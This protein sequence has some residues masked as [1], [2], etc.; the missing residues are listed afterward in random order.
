MVSTMD[1]HGRILGFLDWSRYFFF[2]IASQLYSVD[3]IPDPLL[4]RKSG[5]DG[6]RTKNLWICSQKLWPLDHRSGQIVATCSTNQWYFSS[7]CMVSHLRRPYLL[8]NCS[9]RSW[10]GKVYSFLQPTKYYVVLEALVVY[11]IPCKC[12]TVC[13][14]QTRPPVRQR[15]EHHWYI[16][17]HHPN[18]STTPECYK[19]LG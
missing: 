19:K 7:N 17:V 10:L 13:T 5:S 14:G 2:Q 1:A 3:P 9:L 11:N 18:K 16:L 4:L 8:C 6:N 12:K 15:W